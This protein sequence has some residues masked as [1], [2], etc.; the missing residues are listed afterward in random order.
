MSRVYSRVAAASFRPAGRASIPHGVT[1]AAWPTSE[2]LLVITMRTSFS[3]LPAVAGCTRIRTTPP[4]LIR[5]RL[6]IAICQ[7][8]RSRVNR[9]RQSVLSRLAPER[10]CHRYSEN[11]CPPTG[12]RGWQAAD[13]RRP[14]AENSRQRESA[15]MPTGTM[16]TGARRGIR[17]QGDSHMQDRQASLPAS[18]GGSRRARR[19]RSLPQREVPG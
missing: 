2:S 3:T 4:F 9:I 5:S 1:R 16:P 7:K 8:S 12:H 14:R 15:S 6:W 19:F 18:N 17:A 10:P 13:I 11:H